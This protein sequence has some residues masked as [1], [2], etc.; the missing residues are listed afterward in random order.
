MDGLFVCPTHQHVAEG[1]QPSQSLEDGL[2][3]TWQGGRGGRDG[4]SKEGRVK[5]AAQ[6][7]QQSCAKFSGKVL[8]STIHRSQ[9]SF[10]A[11]TNPRHQQAAGVTKEI[12]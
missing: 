5:G 11:P 12:E 2:E 3:A 7:V 10:L 9:R 4:T 8:T 6:K 1:K